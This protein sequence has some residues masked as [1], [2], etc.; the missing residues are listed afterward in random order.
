MNWKPTAIPTSSPMRPEAVAEM[1]TTSALAP[2]PRTLTSAETALAAQFAQMSPTLPGSRAVH[3]ARALAMAT[4]AQNGLPTRKVEA[5]HYTDLRR[6]LTVVPPVEGA[7]ERASM[8]PLVAGSVVLDDRALSAVLPDGLTVVAMADGLKADIGGVV[9]HF[10]GADDAIGIINTAFADHGQRIVIADDVALDQPLEIRHGVS[11]GQSHSLDHVTVGK[12]ASVLIIDRH[13]GGTDGAALVSHVTD[14]TVRAGAAATFVIIQDHG[15]DTTH[16]GKLRLRLEE[17]AAATVFVA[18]FGGQLVRQEIEAVAAGE[19][20][21]LTLR[22]INLI[23][24]QTHCDVTL[25]LGHVV[26]NT[27]STETV[28]T[29]VTGRGQGVFQGQIRVAPIAQ[30]TDARMACNTLLLSDDA[31]FATK[32]ELEIFADDVVCAHGATVTEIEQDHLFYLM[33]RGIPEKA[34]RGLLIKAF[35]AEIVE[36]LE[37]EALVEALEQRI[38][39]WLEANA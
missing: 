8:A 5:F 14:L 13:H 20:S 1:I 19:G 30:K 21:S 35:V 16:L 24:G 34:A 31:S 26:P 18:N 11:T 2:A 12:G 23:G 37:H 22:A 6:L 25:T 27:T 32:P 36:E 28:R 4:L 9:P 29:V 3:D 7:E 33:A 17:K 15:L 38:D 39:T 10:S